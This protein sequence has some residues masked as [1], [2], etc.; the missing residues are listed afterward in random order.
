MKHDKVFVWR[1]LR[2]IARD[3]FPAFSKTANEGDLD[4]AIRALYPE[5]VPTPAA[6]PG[7]VPETEVLDVQGSPAREEEPCEEGPSDADRQVRPFAPPRPGF[8]VKRVPSCTVFCTGVLHR[9]GS[10]FLQ[11]RGY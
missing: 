2:L 6:K 3:N 11:R 4:E 8:P 1:A 10:A 9:R 7:A 5:E